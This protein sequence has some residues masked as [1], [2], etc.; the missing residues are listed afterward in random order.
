MVRAVWAA[1]RPVTGQQWFLWWCGTVLL[2]S[3]LVHGVIAL[4]DGGPWLGPVSWRKP[5]VFG[6]SFGLLAWS[7]VWV[8]R[9]LRSRAWGWVPVGLLGAT[10]L[11]EVGLITLQRWRGVPSHFS[12]DPGFNE[13]VFSWMGMSVVLVVLALMIMLVWTAV[14]FRGARV[15]KI[16]A[17]AGLVAQLVAG[18]IG[19]DMIVAG[20]AVVDATGQVPF[21]LVFGAAGSAK[22]A[23]AAGI[24]AIQVFA[25]LA[26][27]LGTRTRVMLA[28]VAGY[29]AVF[30]ALAAT[31]Y[32]G[33]AWTSPA[34]LIGVLGVA[35]VVVVLGAGLAALRRP[36]LG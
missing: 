5:V 17:V 23:H 12:R 26:I 35:G 11:I 7:V 13:D 9:N 2:A 22:L 32:A 33:R 4:L 10:S 6:L 31:A 14:G 25:V 19:R 1:V 29:A 28:A 34:P 24:H 21:D 20:E 30:A 15:A 18:W 36:A 8:L 27:L 16:A 3:G